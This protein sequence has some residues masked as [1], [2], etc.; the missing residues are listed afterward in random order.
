MLQPCINALFNFT[1]SI[2]YRE[3]FQNY[4]Q[5]S[6]ALGTSKE[7]KEKIEKDFEKL[8]QVILLS[9]KK[10]LLKAGENNIP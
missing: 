5:F 7:K 1:K 3:L 8:F 4:T 6:T 10:P 9:V 2:K